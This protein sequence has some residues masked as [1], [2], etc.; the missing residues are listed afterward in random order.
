MKS[1]F[2][3]LLL[4]L[5]SLVIFVGCKD[6]TPNNSASSQGAAYELIVVCAQPQWEGA[7]GD[8]LREILLHPVHMINQREPLF[9]VL[10][11]LPA[12]F[13]K[14]VTKHRNILIINVSENQQEPQILVRTNV[15]ATPQLVVTVSAPDNATMAQFLDESRS[16][17]LSLF[18]LAERERDLNAMAKYGPKNLEDTILNRFGLQLD[19]PV[20]FT[21][22]S[23]KPDFMWLS[24]EMPQSSQGLFVYSYP[25]T[26]REDFTLEA[27][28][29]ARNRFAALI[30]GP[31]DGSYMITVPDAEMKYKKINGRS[32][33]EMRGFWDV[34]GDFMGGPFVSYSTVDTQTKGIITIDCYVYS[35]KLPKRNYLRAL[36]HIV[37]SASIPGDTAN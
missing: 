37:Y 36:E 17:L 1:S 5:F 11:V 30:P 19:L 24:Y 2:R 23:E 21:L 14:L 34:H 29:A 18:E 32:W 15:Y 10:R 31:S 16:E 3:T 22:R 8:T 26:G 7:V 12:G 25:Y 28:V 6:G 33:A 13:N 20:G 9:D 27:L 35:P 4:T